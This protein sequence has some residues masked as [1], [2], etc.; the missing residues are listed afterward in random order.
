M[1]ETE[2][3]QIGWDISYDPTTT[4]DVIMLDVGDDSVY[5]T[6]KDLEEMLGALS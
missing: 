5:L 4:D 3:Q 6:A 2:L 1:N